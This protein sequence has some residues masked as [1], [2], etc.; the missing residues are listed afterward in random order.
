[1][2]KQNKSNSWAQRN[3]TLQQVFSMLLGIPLR[4]PQQGGGLPES[5]P[6]NYAPQNENTDAHPHLEYL[7][8]RIPN[9]YNFYQQ[10][11]NLRVSPVIPA[12][13]IIPV[14]N[15][16]PPQ[17]NIDDTFAGGFKQSLQRSHNKLKYINQ[18]LQQIINQEKTI[19]KGLRALDEAGVDYSSRLAVK[20]SIAKLRR[21]IINEQQLINEGKGTPEIKASVAHK[22]RLMSGLLPIQKLYESDGATPEEVM[23][24][25]EIYRTEGGPGMRSQAKLLQ[26]EDA[27]PELRGWGKIGAFVGD[28][29]VAAPV[30]GASMMAPPLGLA[31]GVGSAAFD[32]YATTNMEA[33]RIERET[34][35]KISPVRR[36]VQTGI[37]TLPSL[38]TKKIPVDK[39]RG[40]NKLPEWT[41][42]IVQETL[43]QGG[44]GGLYSLT[45]D[46]G[47]NL[48]LGNDISG[49][50]IFRNLGRG[51]GV[52]VV[53]GAAAGSGSEALSRL[54]NP[55][56]RIPPEPYQS[57]PHGTYE[58]GIMNT[59]TNIPHKDYG[60][61]FLQKTATVPQGT[62]ESGAMNT[63][64]NIPFKDYGL[65]FQ[66]K[67][68]T[69]PQ[70]TYESGAMNTPTNIPFKDYGLEFQ[71]KTATVPQ[72][73][74]ESGAMNTPA[75]IPFGSYRSEI[76]PQ[77]TQIPYGTYQSEVWGR[78]VEIPHG[79]HQSKTTG[80]TPPKGAQEN[81]NIPHG[82]YESEA[83]GQP[84]RIPYGTYRSE[85]PT[86][87]IEIP[88]GTYESEAFGQ[89]T[90]IPHGTY[91]SEIPMQ[92]IELPHGIY[93]LEIQQQ[94]T[95][96]PHGTYRSDILG[97][98]VRIPY[99]IH[100]SGVLN[101]SQ[102]VPHNTYPA[103]P[104]VPYDTYSG[105]SSL[106]PPEWGNAPI[107]IQPDTYTSDL[108]K[109]INLPEI[110][111]PFYPYAKAF[112]IEDLQKGLKSLK[113][114]RSGSKSS[115]SGKSG[116]K[117]KKR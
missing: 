21:E 104:T 8:D 75:N 42:N 78:Q 83:F 31:A 65:E 111:S 20:S 113:I 2:N 50:E 7:V 84:T 76:P 106:V 39:I 24:W 32:S 68:A 107:R 3:D 70:G 112:G 71:Q 62:Y 60:S 48:A 13:Y 14:R 40:I 94:P 110:K 55:F 97:E 88:H 59:P 98:P 114:N 36:F 74:Y 89:P 53:A 11:D 80:I 109:Y 101:E 117:K 77:T 29:A 54:R 103:K 44:L 66:Q 26:E 4:L 87:P 12:N 37:N 35:R 96:I 73:T 17:K 9:D 108:D 43:R 28:A 116:K 49:G 102:V 46:I 33:D 47:S 92:P 79:V 15:E 27:Y 105:H 95:E 56:R 1:M 16:V 38:I 82:T 6:Q 18:D 91:R 69:V 86:Q 10:P 99:D 52:G 30:V 57:V 64:T 45:H 19:Q 61:E 58:S 100:E 34:G 90:R 22:R 115:K 41:Q 25:A 85:I 5:I 93:Q 67:T 23:S 51:M 63:P 72:G 81:T